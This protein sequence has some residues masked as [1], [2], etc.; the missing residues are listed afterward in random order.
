[1]AAARSARRQ[2]ARNSSAE[3]SA[4]LGAVPREQVRDLVLP[5]AD[6]LL[7]GGAAVRARHV[8]GRAV[9]EQQPGQLR[10]RLHLDRGGQRRNRRRLLV[11]FAEQAGVQ[12]MARVGSGVQ[13]QPDAGDIPGADRRGQRGGG[14]DVRCVRQQQPQAFVITLERRQVQ[15]MIIGPGAVLQQQPGDGRVGRARDRAQQ[16]RPLAALPVRAASGIGAGV[17]Q[18]PRDLGQPAGRAG[19]SRCHREAHAAC[20]AVHPVL[21]SRRVASAGSWASIS[22]TLAASPRMTAVRK[23]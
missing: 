21:P 16:R 8:R 2:A 22:R 18:Q 20:K 5:G 12:Q 15:H 6:G 13:Q 4:V 7:V 14:G 17:Q 19:S 3:D 23:S 10:P 1:M 11:R 9:L